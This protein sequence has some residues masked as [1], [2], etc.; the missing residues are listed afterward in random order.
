MSERARGQAAG[1]DEAGHQRDPDRVVGA[2]LA[3]QDDVAA[4]GDLPLAKDGEHDRRVGRRHRR[5]KEHRGI[6]AQA[7]RGMREQRARRHGQERSRHAR[8]GDR[9]G[10]GPEPGPADLHPAVEQDEHQGDRDHP[11]DYQ[12]RRRVQRRDDL[13]RHGRAHKDQRRGRDLNPL[14]Q[15]VRQH[16]DQPHRSGQQHQQGKGLSVCHNGAPPG[17]GIAEAFP[18]RLPGAPL[19]TVLAGA[20]TASPCAAP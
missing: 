7:E 13:D 20:G 11:L 3:F 18:T 8:H 15:P 6:P 14:G 16:H 2:R 12:V 1:G 9:D 19:P 4:A 17:S 10:S 5:G